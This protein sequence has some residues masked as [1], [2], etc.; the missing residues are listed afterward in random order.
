MDTTELIIIELFCQQYDVEP[1][2]VSELETVGLIE[3]ITYNNSK[4]LP[5]NQLFTIE[6]IIRLHNE[7][8]INKEGIDVIL[9]LLEKIN[10][11]QSEVKYL[12]NRLSLYE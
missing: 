3:T 8:H 12:N 1:T 10:Q 4:Y 11:L 9:E 5:I 7:L 6:K 2:F